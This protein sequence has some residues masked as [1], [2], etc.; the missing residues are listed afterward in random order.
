[1]PLDA[2][3]K[4][5]TTLPSGSDYVDTISY[6]KL[7]DRITKLVATME[8]MKGK[9][10]SSRRLRY[11][12]IDI[13][14][15]RK[16][17]RLA[18]DE[19]YLPQHMID[20]NIRREQSSYIQYITQSPRAVIL[21]DFYTPSNDT[22]I[23]ERDATNKIR[24]EGWQ[25]SLYRVIDAFQQDG[26]SICELVH[27]QSKG[28]ELAVE[29]VSI[30]DFGFVLDSKDL[31]M[32]EQVVRRYYFTRTAL[33]GFT[34]PEAEDGRGWDAEE[35]NIVI[36]STEGSSSATNN[37]S[38]RDHSLYR[39]EKV[40]FRVKGVVQV[41]WCSSE[42]GSDW[43]RAPR[44]LYI[45]RQKKNS[46]VDMLKKRTMKPFDSD[47]ETQYTYFLFPYL[48]S[49]NPTVS[50]LKGRV[51]LDQDAQEGA[52]SL[53]SS[54]VTAHR[55]AAGLYFSK[56]T[57]DPNDD[58]L[59]QKNVYFKTGA[60]IN[61]K[62]TQFQLA[63]PSSDML[64]AINAV[65]TS[66]AAETSQVNFAAQNRKDSRKTAT[67]IT[68]SQQTQQQ[69]STVQVV[70][71]STALRQLY[72][73]MFDI[74]QSRVVSGLIEVDPTIKQM[75]SRKYV[76]KPSGDTDVIERQQKISAMQQAWPVIQQTPAAL[77]FLMKLMSL[78]F[79]DDAPQYNQILQQAQQAQQQ[80][81]NQQGM[82]SGMIEKA[83][84][85]ITGFVNNPQ[86]VTPQ[87]KQ[88]AIGLEHQLVQQMTPQQPQAQ[89]AQLQAPQQQ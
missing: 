40:M 33:L 82:I 85:V 81:Q 49:E 27:D 14:A 29:E 69:L 51:Y 1:M 24:Y 68:A 86:Y 70:L 4:D 80:G 78:L 58:I 23:L 42:K 45:G 22:S 19:L 32:C 8:D 47:Y 64:A 18:P 53:M 12:E 44:P 56:D 60:L 75:Y 62:V 66:N 21:Q 89:Q 20:S 25:T 30:G 73:T 72:Q 63:A 59:M 5:T 36:S 31:Q 54:F 35:V 46:V 87:G 41:A 84:S 50:E 43:L 83:I 16:S 11:E 67:E 13:E 61:A 28:G 26:Y 6:D 74:I 65:V 52:A 38:Y 37:S 76:V 34:K 57:S 71:F 17:G 10:Q 3:Q 15:E 2:T 77:P 79:P 55:R 88:A 39:V 48:V 7:K 9:L